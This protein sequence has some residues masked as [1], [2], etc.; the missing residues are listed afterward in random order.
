MNLG[1][2]GLHEGCNMGNASVIGVNMEF[3]GVVF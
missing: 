1:N 3:R 2:S